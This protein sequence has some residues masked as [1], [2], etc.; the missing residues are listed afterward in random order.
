VI[1]RERE[2][3]LMSFTDV[4]QLALDKV[5]QIPWRLWR[6]VIFPVVVFSLILVLSS[7]INHRYSETGWPA[8][9]LNHAAASEFSYEEPPYPIT[10]HALWNDLL[11]LLENSAPH[12][13]SKPLVDVG[14]VSEPFEEAPNVALMDQ[15][16]MYPQDILKMARAHHLFTAQLQTRLAVHLAQQHRPLQRPVRRGIVMVAGGEYMPTAIVSIRML[17]RSGSVLPVELWMSSE[18]EYEPQL[19]TD[20]LPAFNVT[21][22]LLSDVFHNATTRQSQAI[23]GF[24][25]KIFALLFSSFDE[26]LFLDADV[27]AIQNPD[28]LFESAPFREKGMITW[29]D[30]WATSISPIYYL[31]TGQTETPL[32]GERASTESGQLMINK[33]THMETLLVA[34]YY[35][36]YNEWYYVLLCQVRYA[37]FFLHHC[38]RMLITT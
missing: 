12:T 14:I 5:S 17:R 6:N 26:V 29:P 11:R 38:F 22:R 36:Y 1:V 35:N 27:V 19:C 21:C 23:A 16:Q 37:L 2:T 9:I 4:S 3:I 31:I 28:G 32:V 18:E 13:F 25:Y 8:S 24:Q 33:R 7:S 30:L 10:A 34:T 15:T 20:I